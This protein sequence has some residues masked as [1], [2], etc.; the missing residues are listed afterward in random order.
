MKIFKNNFV[1][2]FTVALFLI[3]I[4]IGISYFLLYKPDVTSY[5]EEFKSLILSSKQNTFFTSLGI[6]SFIFVASISI[7][8]IPIVIFLIFYEGVSIGF[9]IATF[10]SI[11][12]LKGLLFYV[13]FFLTCKAIF[14]L[15]IGYFVVFSIRYAAKFIDA[16]KNKNKEALYRTIVYHFY[17]FL[18]VLTIVLVN[19][20]LIYFFSNILIKKIIGLI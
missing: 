14:I 18:I 11:A 17:R 8:G 6:I 4:L 12:H 3:G 15:A 20:T 13:L 1:V 2:K 16:I 9:T 7:I 19:S 10:F 5:V